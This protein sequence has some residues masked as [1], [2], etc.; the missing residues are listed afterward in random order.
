MQ[1]LRQRYNR[2][3]MRNSNRGIPH[4]M[5]WLCAGSAIVYLFSVFT[6]SQELYDILSFDANAILHGQVWRL[7]S[8]VFTFAL[9]RQ[10]LFSTLLGAIFSILFYYW[11]GNLL[12][13]FWGT[14]RFNI[15]YL[16]GVLLMDIAGLLMHLIFKQFGLSV[17]LPVSVSYL[18]LSLFLAAATLAPEERVYFMLLIPIKM[19]WLALVYLILSLISVVSGVVGAF[20]YL[21][22]GQTLL[23]AGW[24]CYALF[25]LVALLNYFLFF[26]KGVRVLFPNL[27][28]VHK[29]EK[30][31][32]E[33]YR[34]SHEATEN[35]SPVYRVEVQEPTKP[36]GGGRPY[37][38]K[39]TVC[40]RTD[41]DCPDLEFRYC[42]KCKGYFCYC[43]DHINNHTHVQ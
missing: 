10:F 22:L 32:A 31:K 1:K 5:L 19:K 15:F 28:R 23:F 35:A 13:N 34:R 18:N 14:L 25:P 2:F 29:Q 41:A 43:I 24:L 37:R 20:S 17:N 42:S 33:Y 6:G 30:R 11:I 4:L 3:V 38:H 7:F 21:K 8:Y 16:S 39:C 36:A 12:E 40:G 27:R 9:D 26:G